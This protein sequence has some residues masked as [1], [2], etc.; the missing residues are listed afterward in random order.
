M[1][2]HFIPFPLVGCH[3][4]DHTTTRFE[5]ASPRVVEVGQFVALHGLSPDEIRPRKASASDGVRVD[6]ADD[7]WDGEVF[8]QRDDAHAG[9]SY[10]IR[11]DRGMSHAAD[12]SE[13]DPTRL[14]ASGIDRKSNQVE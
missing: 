7:L 6:G 3:R 11:R 12:R 14:T 2:R 10:V 5:T 1:T 13:I 4:P 9:F 8:L